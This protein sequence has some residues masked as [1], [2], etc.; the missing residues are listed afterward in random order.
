M[1]KKLFIIVFF[2]YAILSD[3]HGNLPALTAVMEKLKEFEIDG[4]ICAGDLV[5]YNPYPNEVVEF[6]KKHFYVCIRGNHDRAVVYNDFR[7]FNTYAEIAGRWT[8]E[9]LTPENMMYLEKLS[10][11]AVLV[12]NGVKIAVHHGAPFD[13]D[14]YVFEDMVDESLLE[15]D[16]VDVLILGHT[17]IPFI[18]Q[19]KNGVVLNPGSVGQPRDGDWRASVCIADFE[20]QRYEIFRVE[21]DV[22]TVAKKISEESL[23]SILGE[24]LFHGF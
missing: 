7:K 4:I 9:R 6:A 16:T 20:E 19:F 24:R 17:H 13:E 12:L 11:N 23:P 2:M 14:F 22:Q 1:F 8:R 5:G 18:K 3:I 21:Y 10:D 15:Y